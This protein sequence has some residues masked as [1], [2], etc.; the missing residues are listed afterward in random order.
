METIAG[1]GYNEGKDESSRT[2]K[3]NFNKGRGKAN[4]VRLSDATRGVLH[5][6]EKPPDR[7]HGMRTSIWEPKKGRDAMAEKTTMP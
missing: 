7:H 5:K 4:V 6:V 1:Y 3:L 2:N